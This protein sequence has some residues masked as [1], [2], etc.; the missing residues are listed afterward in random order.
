MRTLGEFRVLLSSTQLTKSLGFSLPVVNW[1]CKDWFLNDLPSNCPSAYR[2]A[3]LTTS[4][5]FSFVARQLYI[6]WAWCIEYQRAAARDLLSAFDA[7]TEKKRKGLK[8]I[9]SISFFIVQFFHFVTI[10]FIEQM[11]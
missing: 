5:F 8:S 3:E 2:L 9:T 4:F 7:I 1:V 10:A 6:F 11:G